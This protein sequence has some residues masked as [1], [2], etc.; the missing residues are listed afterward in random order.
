MPRRGLVGFMKNYRLRI[1][2]EGFGVWDGMGFGGAGFT[3]RV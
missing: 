1:V 2:V 3:A